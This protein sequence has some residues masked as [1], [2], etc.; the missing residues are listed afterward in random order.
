MCVADF[1]IPASLF[2]FL[3]WRQNQG[4]FWLDAS[5]LCKLVYYCD[6]TQCLFCIVVNAIKK[7]NRK[8]SDLKPKEVITNTGKRD[9]Y[10]MGIFCVVSCFQFSFVVDMAG[11]PEIHEALM[12]TRLFDVRETLQKSKVRRLLTDAGLHMKCSIPFIVLFRLFLGQLFDCQGGLFERVVRGF[13]S[14]F[15][16]TL[17]FLITVACVALNR[18]RCSRWAFTP[19]EVGCGIVVCFHFFFFS[20][21]QI[22]D[23][24]NA[25]TCLALGLC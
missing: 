11:I 5:D 8:K 24:A 4:L 19:I 13:L 16:L 22:D 1:E 18:N 21:P 14:Y 10:S 15:C 12:R 9:Q 6:S 17:V 23:A 3:C 20:F 2:D 25:V 7:E